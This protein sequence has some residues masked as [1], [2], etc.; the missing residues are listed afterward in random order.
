MKR[1]YLRSQI[2]GSKKYY[3]IVDIGFDP[4]IK[5]TDLLWNLR[6][7]KWTLKNHNRDH[8]EQWNL[9]K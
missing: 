3:L 5:L 1:V 7:V 8:I 6:A 4:P 9:I 2:I